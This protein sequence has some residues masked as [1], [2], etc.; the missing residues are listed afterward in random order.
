[1]TFIYSATPAQQRKL[2]AQIAT[3]EQQSYYS[4]S[5][6]QHLDRNETAIDHK[7][8]S[9]PN[10]KALEISDPDYVMRENSILEHAANDI[11]TLDPSFRLARQVTRDASSFNRDDSGIVDES[12]EVSAAYKHQPRLFRGTTVQ[13]SS[14]AEENLNPRSR[15]DQNLNQILKENTDVFVIKQAVTRS[16]TRVE[17]FFKTRNEEKALKKEK[18]QQEM[19][20]NN[21]NKKKSVPEEF[22]NHNLMPHVASYLTEDEIIFLLNQRASRSSHEDI[23]S[24]GEDEGFSDLYDDRTQKQSGQ[25]S[26]A[27]MSPENE[28]ESWGHF[29]KSEENRGDDF[30]G[31]TELPVIKS[32]SQS[33]HSSALKLQGDLSVQQLSSTY[34]PL[35]RPL[36]D[37]FP[38]LDMPIISDFVSKWER[39]SKSCEP[40]KSSAFAQRP[41]SQY[42]YNSLVKKNCRKSRRNFRLSEQTSLNN[43]LTVPEDD[44]RLSGDSAIGGSDGKPSSMYRLLKQ[45]L[46]ICCSYLGTKFKINKVH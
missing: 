20:Q 26:A 17:T 28:L 15:T 21:K 22:K 29:L 8:Y 16:P 4:A 32:D 41:T 46:S 36:S 33:F 12:R 6:S 30:R 34:R 40:T 14:L 25:K 3:D 9:T 24:L 27:L 38:I 11:L 13:F 39:T 7:L 44:G 42:M 43:T 37:N 2:K 45:L 19:L 10:L 1:M 5:E 18:R 31:E 35:D 23:D